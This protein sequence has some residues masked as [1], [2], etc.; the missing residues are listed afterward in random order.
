ME[1]TVKMVERMLREVTG[2]KRGPMWIKN[3][4]VSRLI[5]SNKCN[6]AIGRRRAAVI[7]GCVAQLIG[8]GG[9][10]NRNMS[11]TGSQSTMLVTNARAELGEAPKGE[12]HRLEMKGTVRA[13]VKENEEEAEPGIYVIRPGKLNQM[14]SAKKKTAGTRGGP[15]AIMAAVVDLASEGVATLRQV[16]NKANRQGKWEEWVEDTVSWMVEREWIQE[17]EAHGLE[18]KA[19]EMN[20]KYTRRTEPAMLVLNIGEGW[21]SVG[22]ALKNLVPGAYIA[23]ADRRGHTYTG[24]TYGTITAE[25]EHDWTHQNRDL[26]TALSK[27]V[28]V[29]PKAW[30]LIT[31]EME[32]TLFSRAN[33]VN[34]ANGS[35]HGKWA[36]TTTNRANAKPGRV[37][38]EEERYSMAVG[39]VKAQID[40][41]ERHPRVPFLVENPAQSDLW[42][43]EVVKRAMAKNKEWRKVRV[44]RCAYGRM[45]QKSTTFLTNVD[46]TPRGRT[47]NGRCGSGCTGSLMPSGR[48]KHEC[49]TMASSADRHV[50][51]GN[52]DQGT[53]YEMT[54]DAVVNAVEEELLREFLEA[55]WAGGTG[56]VDRK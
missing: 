16:P 25:I 24:T 50:R 15:M 38:M 35:A 55:L 53:R 18:R 44:D 9:H 31:L 20:R 34:Q 52:K 48:I 3:C 45:E 5:H 39:A 28:S 46:W 12:A 56:I 36:M 13:W 1:E 10:K 4:H 23:G 19:K 32:C 41:L 37:E 29:S 30:D 21:R 14:K 7:W 40:S 22:R 8:T 47:G 33:A 11:I 51:R 42:D 6:K 54:R 17:S 26:I 43:L 49:Q 27:K 2:V